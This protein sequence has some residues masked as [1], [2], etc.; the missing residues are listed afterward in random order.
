MDLGVTLNDTKLRGRYLARL[1]HFAFFDLSMKTAV[2]LL[3]CD[4]YLK[5][6]T[7][8]L[9]L[10]RHNWKNHPP[11]YVCGVSSGMAG[12]QVIPFTVDH[13][14]WLGIAYEAM[15]VLEQEGFDYCYLILDDHP[16]VGRCNG[17]YLQREL[18]E[19]A[20]S[21][22][23]CVVSLVGWDQIRNYKGH[24]LD[25]SCHYWLKND[26]DYR[27]L[28]N[29]HPGCWRI[30]ALRD[31]LGSL[32]ASAGSD[33][34]ARAFEALGGASN[35]LIPSTYRDSS[36]RVCGDRYA[37]AKQWFA[38]PRPRSLL[39]NGLHAVRFGAKTFGGSK[40]LGRVDQRAKLYTD[41]LNGP[42]PMFWSGL[43]QKGRVH[44]NAVRF[45]RLAG[46]SEY[47]DQA[48]LL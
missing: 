2:L 8:T 32:M 36:Y 48:A 41:Y 4:S 9:S 5:V 46:L 27:W 11:I 24:R 17:A 15:T 44:Q 43:M 22:N 38:R 6:A 13:R 10:L 30:S 19:L 45:L 29:L 3:T 21:L 37:V 26:P 34:S 42:Y 16:P 12:E 47:A 40:L 1:E 28:F 7:L 25:A 18:P 20:R 14:D 23:A 31:I 35:S 33:R 39:L